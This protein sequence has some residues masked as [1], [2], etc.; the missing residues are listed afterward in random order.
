MTII[1][2]TRIQHERNGSFDAVDAFD[3]RMRFEGIPKKHW[4]R[5]SASSL[6]GF[7][8]IDRN[9]VPNNSVQR[10]S[11]RV[12]RGAKTAKMMRCVLVD[13]AIWIITVDFIANSSICVYVARTLKC[14]SAG[15]LII[16]YVTDKQRCSENR[17]RGSDAARQREGD[18]DASLGI[19]IEII[20]DD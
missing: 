2:H 16:E 20:C 14:L 7:E 15:D 18:N 6:I 9:F 5:Q 19:C 4:H 13:V 12:S 1:V 10:K 17:Q 3:C 8:N 11:A